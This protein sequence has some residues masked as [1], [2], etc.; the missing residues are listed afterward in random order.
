MCKGFKRISTNFVIKK[1]MNK[2]IPIYI[3]GSVTI[4]LGILLVNA[5]QINFF[6][7]QLA[8]GIGSCIGALMAFVAALSRQEK[9]VQ[10][11]YHEMHAM[12]MMIFGILTLLFCNTP[13]KLINY[14]TFLLIF[15][16]FSEII[17]CNWLFNLK[18]KLLFKV[19]LIRVFLG[20]A[21][22]IGTITG[23]NYSEISL[24]IFGVLFVL[25]GINILLYV[26]IMK[27]MPIHTGK[28]IT[29]A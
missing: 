25:V 27:G 5:Q 19:A 26:P 6:S 20:L 13:E 21:I 28:K 17:F 14:I 2:F 16:A 10:F 15:Y 4:L 8:L 9:P 29:T 3:Y 1:K 24:E 11:A 23:M 18:Q 7:L 12:T 22:G